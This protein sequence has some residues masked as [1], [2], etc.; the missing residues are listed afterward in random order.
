MTYE[1]IQVSKENGVATITLNRPPMNPLN[2]QIFKELTQ[3]I[4]ELQSDISVGAV[5][6][7]GSG[8]KAFA[9]GA[10]VTEMANLTP[11]EVYNFCQDSQIAFKRIENLGKPVIAAINGLALGGGC[12]LAL[13]CDFRV[14]A[15]T[16]K[17][18]QPE[19][20]L[21]IIPGAGGTQRLPRLI[22][23]A[24][25]KE[26]IFLGDI[27]DASAALG[28]GLVNKVVPTELLLEEA[29][30]LAKRLSSKPAVAMAMAKSAINT[31]L[32]LDISSALTL[33]IQCFVTAFASDDRK[34]G[35][36]AFMEKRK[37]NF[38]GK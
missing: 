14:A 35:I 20:G 18:G 16:A 31:G 4:N 2:T 17:F 22:G 7:T 23:A 3:A 32:N 19:I 12:E 21:G 38:T 9:A 36:G 6:M 28:L 15:D 24:K 8:D 5:I 33:E 27:I 10:D 37:P 11:V 34:E 29:Q 1:A 30:K 25:A 26:L 13:C